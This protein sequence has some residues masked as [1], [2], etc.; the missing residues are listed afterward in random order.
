MSAMNM[1]EAL[2]SAHDV[3]MARDD[4]VVVMGEDVGFFGG[5]FRV[6]A[7]LQKKYGRSRV[8]DAPISEGGIM[9]VAIGMA[10]YGLRPVAEIQFA[11]VIQRRHANPDFAAARLRKCKCDGLR[12]AM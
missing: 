12:F 1:I 10:T 9:G 8:F 4:D 5:V 3:M 11:D 2:N 7:G 6:T